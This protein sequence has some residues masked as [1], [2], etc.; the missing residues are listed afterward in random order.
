MNMRHG[1]EGTHYN[2]VK[3]SDGSHGCCACSPNPEG[4]EW[5]IQPLGMSG[6]VAKEENHCCQ[7]GYFGDGH[8]CAKQPSG[9]EKEPWWQNPE[10]LGRIIG[11]KDGFVDYLF[12]HS[13][14]MSSI[15]AEARRLAI[16]ECKEIVE[17]LMPTEPYPSASNGY[18]KELDPE[19]A[20]EKKI[21]DYLLSRFNTL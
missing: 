17:R 2:C 16:E 15:I 13:P 6:D 18:S 9:E 3:H 10:V 12:L 14:H 21:L 8:M 7:Y 1:E 4:C 20:T 5:D 11:E 19:E